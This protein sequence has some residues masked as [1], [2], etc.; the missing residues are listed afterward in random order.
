MFNSLIR[1]FS[2]YDFLPYKYGP[3]SFYADSDLTDLNE[4]NYIHGEKLNIDAEKREQVESILRNI[5]LQ[6]RNN[7]KYLVNQYGEKNDKN[8]V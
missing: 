2:F 3:Y 6:P 1:F 5:P 7:I 8:I 4:E